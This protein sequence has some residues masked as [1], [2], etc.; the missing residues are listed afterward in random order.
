M[1]QPPK[2]INHWF[3][4]AF[5][6]HVRPLF[7]RSLSRLAALVVPYIYVAYMRLVWA[8]SRIEGGTEFTE[9]IRMAERHD[10]VVALLWH[11]EV[12]TVAFG[13]P[14]LGIRGHTLASLGESG[15]VI[16]RMLQ[17]L[18][19]RRLPRR[20]DQRQVATARRHAARDDRAHADDARGHLRPHRRRL[21]G[22]G[23]PD[24]DRA[25]S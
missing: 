23:L 17:A 1:V 12:M 3:R 16:A 8:T 2:S 11:E 14:Y 6:H 7:S 15:E 4:R 24:E 9:L 13:Y 22:T 19:L 20:L 5:R 18:R 25:G 21:E 10:G